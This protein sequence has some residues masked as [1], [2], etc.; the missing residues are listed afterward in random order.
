MAIQFL[1][2]ENLTPLFVMSLLVL[3]LYR[4][5]PIAVCLLEHSYAILYPQIYLN[6]HR[7]D[8]RA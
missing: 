3:I 7:I 4:M 1:D 2:E 5:T 6:S 8:I